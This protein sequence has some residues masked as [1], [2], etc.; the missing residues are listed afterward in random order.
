MPRTA[1][2]SREDW[3]AAALAALVEGGAS[4]VAV[5]PVAAR[6]GASK[7]SFYWLFE[8]RSALL[9]AALELWEREQTERVASRFTGIADPVERLRSLLLLS[10]GTGHAD[11]A[12]RL[13]CEADEAVRAVA[14]RVTRRRLEI[15]EEAFRELG[16]SAGQARHRAASAYAS[17]LGTAA[18]ARVGA[19]PHDTD[20]YVDEFLATY[21]P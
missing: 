8:N 19:A 6:L 18:L 11:A 2:L 21:A 20:A 15:V 16:M 9:D 17:Y 10:L 5:E 12:L 1:R 7:S 14:G 4:A 13:T 3:A